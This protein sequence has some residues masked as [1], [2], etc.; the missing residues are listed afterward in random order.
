[1]SIVTATAWFSAARSSPNQEKSLATWSMFS[2]YEAGTET[3]S[4]PE[5]LTGLLIPLL[6]HDCLRHP[7]FTMLKSIGELLEFFWAH[8]K[9]T[10]TRTPR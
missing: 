2:N 4:R 1:M 7:A 5:I 8:S 6:S 10:A 3:M 9:L